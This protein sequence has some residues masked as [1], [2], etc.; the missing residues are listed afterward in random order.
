M[1]KYYNI[2]NL[3][4]IIVNSNVSK[5]II[6]DIEFQVGFFI[7]SEQSKSKIPKIEI[8]PYAE[9]SKF[10]NH[11]EPESIFYKETSVVGKYLNNANENLCIYK[12][13]GNFI[14]FADYSNFLINLFI[15]ILIVE[16]GYTMIHAAG[17]KS[18]SGLIYIIAGAGGIGKTSI[19]SYA[20][21]NKGLKIL[22]DDI[23][24]IG[25]KEC[26]SFP[27]EFVLKTYHSK[28]HEQILKNNNISLFNFYTIKRFI[29]DN[30]P[31]KSLIIKILK[32]FKLYYNLVR[33]VNP[34]PH[35]ATISPDKIFGKGSIE[36]KGIIGKICYM[37][38]VKDNSFSLTKI[39]NE[40][41][42]NRLLSIIHHEWISYMP[43]LLSLGANDVIN[44]NHYMNRLL[45]IFSETLIDLDL[46]QIKVPYNVSEK[47]LNNFINSKNL[48]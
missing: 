42:S 8:Y 38:R 28:S 29:I 39:N 25:N 11:Y 9:F 41:I 12:S 2:H 24:I 7:A 22:G 47:D 13:N 15:Q 21:I 27:R 17:Y 32:K 34:T 33:L 20:V 5:W 18:S 45:K 40:V 10:R 4:E 26:L 46:L 36:S 6:K 31:F 23:V 35:L 44:L 43:Q 16:Q 48:F 19:V 1:K 37:E 14:I 30:F 3:V